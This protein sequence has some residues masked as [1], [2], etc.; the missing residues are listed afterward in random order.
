[1]KPNRLAR[2][3]VS[4]ICSLA[5]SS[6]L[7]TTY[8]VSSISDLQSKINGAV[9]GDTII[10]AN[11][12]YTTSSPI[13]VGCDGTSTARI[14][15]QAATVGG[16]TISGSD[17]FAFSGAS[18]VTVSG[19]KFKHSNSISLGTSNNHITLSRC[20][21]QLSIPSGTDRSFIHISGDDM[22]IDH[23]ELGP[24]STLGEMLDISG[25]GSQVAR[26]LWVHHSYFHD[27]SAQSG[28][29]AETVRWGLSGLSL[30][31][32]GGICEY[33][34]F[35]R[36][37][38]ENE[39]ISNKSCGNIYRFNTFLDSPGA[40]LSQRHGNDNKF[41]GNYLRNT[42]GTRIFGDRNQIFCNYFEGNTSAI[43]IGNGD[44]DVESGG[45][46]DSHDRPDGTIIVFNTSISNDVHYS[47]SGRT[48]G[49]GATGTT[50]ANNILQGPGTLADLNGTYSG[51]TWAGNIRWNNNAPGDLPSNGYTT[52]NPLLA[53]D[54]N[55]VYHIQSGSPAIGASVGSYS[56]VTVDMDGQ[57]RDSA[58]DVGAD[59][60]SSA[61]ITAKLLT[62]ADV[63]PNAGSSSSSPLSWEAEA[64][65]F[66]TNGAAAALQTD[67]NTSG[68]KWLAL[69]ADGT[70]DWIQFTLPN[71]PAGTYAVKLSYK[72]HPG[73]GILQASVDGVNLGSPLDQYSATITYPEQTFGTVT[74]SST[75]NH[76]L[77]LTCVGIN[78]SSTVFTL[79]ADLISL[80]AGTVQQVAA[81]TFNPPAGTYSGPQSVTIS[82]TTAGASIHYTTDGSTPTPSTGTPYTGPVTISSSLTLKAIAFKTGMIDSTVTSGNYIISQPDFTISATPSSQ[83]VQPG[84]GTS[85]TVNIGN[86]NGFSGTV[87][88]SISG[89]P[90]GAT[91][92]FNPAS[93]NM[94]GSSTLTVSTAASTPAGSYTLTITGTSGSLVHNT[95]VTL[96]VSSPGTTV[97][98]EAENLAVT[99][100]GVGTSVQTDANSSNGKWIELMATATGSWMEFTTGNVNAGT[101]SFSVMWKGNTTRGISDFFVD[102]TQVGGT[103]DQYS[104]T[105]TYPSKTVGTVTFTAAGTHKIR[106]HVVGKN[107]SS[108]NFQL[109]A[110]KFTFTA[111]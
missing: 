69:Q 38:G 46:L 85:Y 24:K 22:E 72:A 49:L 36:C 47:M 84:A 62:T 94:I 111:Q 101:Y 34:L 26:R 58:K 92:S 23:C 59:E 95:T 19:F 96:V 89:L 9:A 27:F 56:S 21:V 35:T 39:L 40:Q 73:R 90:A 77:R 104:A 12:T 31:T 107:A 25:S 51:A 88:L 109:S 45:A 41:Y 79:S 4:V 2:L 17:G 20:T 44:A 74:F 63:G 110:D 75:G 99:D 11:G 71:V 53:K 54:A 80:T 97:S 105:Q 43:Q 103:A 5:A 1:M 29:G 60:F 98:F 16:V 82:T 78:P 32:G 55:G 108:T 86:V 28:N 57:P 76:T 50:F 64:L 102:G 100:S 42:D 52:V 93:V 61:P 6:V 65:A 70:G 7:A 33:N 68:G 83:T 13:N 87:T 8:N 14:T 3:S 15:I 106:M 67:A 48:G 81:P 66:T 10:V 30:S 18:F 37:V 91:A